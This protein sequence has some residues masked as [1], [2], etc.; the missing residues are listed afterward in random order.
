MLLARDL[1]IYSPGPTY[2]G[3]PLIAP[4]KLS[5]AVVFFSGQAPVR[6]C[7]LGKTKKIIAR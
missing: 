1:Y 4:L 6:P 5:I 7:K 2:R 3:W